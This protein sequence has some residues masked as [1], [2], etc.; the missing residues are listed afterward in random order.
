MKKAVFWDYAL[1]GSC[2]NRRFEGTS[3]VTRATRRNIPEDGIRQQTVTLADA[4]IDEIHT[5]LTY[6]KSE[7]YTH[8]ETSGCNCFTILIMAHSVT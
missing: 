4:V 8:T 1:C 3:D 2:N 6:Y 5:R 7:T